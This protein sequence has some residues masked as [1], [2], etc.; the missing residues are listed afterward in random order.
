MTPSKISENEAALPL[1]TRAGWPEELRV[2]AELYPRE[3]WAAHENL[4]GMAQFWLQRHDMFREVGGILRACMSDYRE[5][6]LQGLAL[7]QKLVRPLQFFLGELETH[8]QVE[9]YHY[10][11]RFRAGDARL[12]R[13]FD[14]LDADHHLIHES[15]GKTV[16]AANA[17]LREFGA[18]S[19]A[20][21]MEASHG[22]PLARMSD[23]LRN[24]IDDYAQVS[25][26]LMTRA[27]AHLRDEEDL[28][29]PLILDRTEAALGVAD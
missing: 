22:D 11:P 15:I 28:I 16:E 7:P 13:G 18:A 14:V 21:P 10:F 12:A 3:V 20:A 1:D 17:M 4:G 8:H 19:P 25:D 29:I 24:A 9:D 5:G 27:L 6:R 23:P 2:L 26:L